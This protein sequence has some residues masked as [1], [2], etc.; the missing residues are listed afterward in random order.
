MSYK[1][2]IA[3]TILVDVKLAWDFMRA[4]EFVEVTIESSVALYVMGAI[5]GIL[6]FLILLCILLD[7]TTIV[8]QCK[9]LKARTTKVF[10]YF[11]GVF[12]YYRT[13]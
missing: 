11:A 5:F 7:I 2:N 4:R 9:S 13:T 10:I 8:K 3:I 1:Y 6:G 12:K